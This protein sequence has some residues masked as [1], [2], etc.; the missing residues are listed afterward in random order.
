MNQ[1]VCMNPELSG[2]SRS[3]ADLQGLVNPEPR[4][5]AGQRPTVPKQEEQSRSR[6]GNQG[7]Q[8]PRLTEKFV[9][10]EQA[11]LEIPSIFQAMGER[12]RAREYSLGEVLVP[13]G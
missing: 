13:S 6:D 10:M 11:C 5:Q 3:S 4:R 1:L 12:C 8:Q 2:S 7:M 9:V